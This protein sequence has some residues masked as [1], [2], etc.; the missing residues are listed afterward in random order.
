MIAA[1]R[2]NFG[3]KLLAVFFACFVHFYAAGL[4]N[5]HP[6]HV[7]ILPLTVRNLPPTLM[8]DEKD[9]PS[10]TLTLDGPPEEISHLTDA[11]VTASVDLSHA[12]A[13][14]TAPLP[15]HLS[16]M[17]AD[18]SAE[19]DP[20]P[21]SLLLQPRSRRQFPISADNIGIAPSH[22]T[23][24]APSVVPREAVISG[25]SEAVSAVVRLVAQADPDQAAGAVDDDLTIAALDSSG[26]PVGNVTVTPA[27]VHVHRD[28]MR[29]LARKTLVV[30]P[31][32][33]GSPPAPYR[34][35]SLTVAPSAVTA[36]GSPEDLAAM[37]MLTTSP[38]DLSAATTDVVRR[39]E[40]VVPAGV[41]LSA[42]GPITVTIHILAPPS[43]LPRKPSPLALPANMPAASHPH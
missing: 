29:V 32:L 25:T 41:S 31:N 15:V 39:V 20:G 21:L 26:A 7:L 14:Q 37:G 3:Y 23:L 43:A 1:L 35:G 19:S 33:V 34:F 40:P 16:G 24:A 17:P 10:V 2:H 42:R 4:I 22:Y 8:L 28:L 11:T 6:P 12:R 5:A 38:I 36:E 30:S 13:G 18:V 27:S 9:T